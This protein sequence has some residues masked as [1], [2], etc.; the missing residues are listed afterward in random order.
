MPVPPPTSFPPTGDSRLAEALA[1]YV[2]PLVMENLPADFGPG[3]EAHDAA[4]SGA[5]LFTD[6]AGFTPL[7][8]HAMAEGPAHP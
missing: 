7:T 5:V 1:A 4:F 2:S 3:A 6:I 8:G